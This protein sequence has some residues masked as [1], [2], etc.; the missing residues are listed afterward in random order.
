V[1]RRVAKHTAKTAKHTT[2]RAQIAARRRTMNAIIRGVSHIQTCGGCDQV[3]CGSTRRLVRQ[4]AQHVRTCPLL[5]CRQCASCTIARM[6]QVAWR[7]VQNGSQDMPSKSK[8]RKC[9]TN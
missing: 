6:V 7:A 1:G 4:C 3:L 2:R 8:C 5:S 9:I